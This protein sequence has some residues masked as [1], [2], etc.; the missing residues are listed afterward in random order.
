MANHFKVSLSQIK[1]QL[2]E[3]FVSGI[4]HIFYHGTTYT[5]KNEAF[6]GW[7]FYA[8]TNYGVHS[9]FWKHYPLLNKYVERCQ[10]ILQNSQADNDLLVYFPIHDLWATKPRAGGGIH[11]LE[12]HHVDK[13]LLKL[14][15]GQLSNW[16]WDNGFAFDFISD[17][18]LQRFASLATK[19]YKTILV[20]ATTYLPQSTLSRLAALS[21]AGAKVIFMEHFPTT[22]TGFAQ[23]SERGASFQ[24]SSKRGRGNRLTFQIL[25]TWKV[26]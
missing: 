9:H 19:K 2:D 18:Q 22:P 4:N 7:L 20:P 10:T 5:P 24:N 17:D 23:Q 8:S 16:L 13:W 25:A 12:V 3:L 26:S 21:K 1:P 15:F 11:Q 6:P 14:P